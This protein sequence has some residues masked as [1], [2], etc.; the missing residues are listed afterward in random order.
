MSFTKQ[1][2]TVFSI[3]NILS[4]AHS[5]L[6]SATSDQNEDSKFAASSIVANQSQSARTSE[7]AIE[8]FCSS[9][10]SVGFWTRLTINMPGA[11]KFTYGKFDSA[12]FEVSVPDDAISNLTTGAGVIVRHSG[13]HNGR[14]FTVGIY[15]SSL[16]GS[17]INY[18]GELFQLDYR[19]DDGSIEDVNYAPIACKR[20]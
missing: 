10:S 13:T 16:E 14:T 9:S 4:V 7:Q 12:L 5:G 6:A 18:S 15:V 20:L 3:L 11:S 1:F 8:F 2:L 19:G 17:D